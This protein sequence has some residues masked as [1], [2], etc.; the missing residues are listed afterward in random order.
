MNVKNRIIALSLAIL[1]CAVPAYAQTPAGAY[2]AGSWHCVAGCSGDTYIKVENGKL[3]FGGQGDAVAH[4]G[5]YDSSTDM[6]T[7]D[8]WNA[9]GQVKIRDN[10]LTIQ[11]LNHTDWRCDSGP[12][13][14]GKPH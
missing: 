9:P 12:C 14:Q 2:L 11:W 8:S 6:V 3:W 5:S 4:E 13:R 10:P 7:V 1:T